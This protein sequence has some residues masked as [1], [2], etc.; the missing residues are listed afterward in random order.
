MQRPDNRHWGCDRSTLL[1]E[2]RARVVGLCVFETGKPTDGGDAVVGTLC[3]A[4]SRLLQE[5]FLLLLQSVAG[6]D[7]NSLNISCL[8][9]EMYHT[10]F[11]RVIFC[12]SIINSV[13]V[14][15]VDL[16]FSIEFQR[17]RV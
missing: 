16:A 10:V 17:N 6:C 12:E 15:N 1:L 11:N 3:L 8:F 9:S 7:Q 14:F 13:K 4:R 2:G 5:S